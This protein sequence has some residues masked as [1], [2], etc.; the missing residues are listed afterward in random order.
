MDTRI[1]SFI[2]C[3][4]GV[5]LVLSAPAP[6]LGASAADGRP[7]A[8]ESFSYFT[9]LDPDEWTGSVTFGDEDGEPL[10]LD[11]QRNFTCEQACDVTNET[12]LVLGGEPSARKIVVEQGDTE[13][14]VVPLSNGQEI[15]TFYDY[16]NYQINS[17]LPIAK[18]DTTRL[19][20]WSGPQGLSLVVLNDKPN[21]GSGGAVTGTFSGLPSEGS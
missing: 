21:D 4:L 20:F 15:E 17:P 10:V 9:V 13:Y 5:L 19:F 7:A 3:I 16:A 18:S 14:E 8:V 12:T 11:A 6:V 2:V 1:R